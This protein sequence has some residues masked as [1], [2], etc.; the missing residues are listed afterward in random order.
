MNTAREWNDQPRVDIGDKVTGRAVYVEDVPE[1]PGTL[2]AAAIRS[3]YSH[4]RIGSIDSAAAERLPGVVAVLHGGNVDRFDIKGAPSSWKQQFIAGDRVRFD[5]DL[6]GLVVAEDAR[7]AHHA[8][9]LVAVDY[10]ALPT[11]FSAQEAL[12][13]DAELIHDELDSNLALSDVWEWGDVQAGL[14]DADVV[15]TETYSCPTIYQHP[16]EPASSFLVDCST[17]VMEVWAPNNKP[18]EI[19]DLG[20]SLF[21]WP[22]DKIRSRVP[23][24]GGNFG[25][26]H[27]TPELLAGIV[28]SHKIRRP[29]K[30]IVSGEESFRSTSRHA[31]D[32]TITMGLKADGTITA[33]DEY[34]AINT[35]AYFTGARVATGN[36]VTAGWG[37]YRI[38]NFRVRAHTAYTNRVP[39]GVFRNTGKNQPSFAIDSM[40]DDAARRMGINPL[41]L[42]VKNLLVRG[43]GLPTETWKRDGQLAPAEVLPMD[44]DIEYLIQ[45]A[46]EAIGWDGRSPAP[47][48]PGERVSRGRGLAISMR[49]GSGMGQATALASV[50]EDGMVSISH[51]AP[52]VGAGEF[53]MISVVAS[54]TMEIP[55]SRIRVGAPD[56]SNELEF[57]GTSSQRTTVQMGSA[58]RNACDELKLALATAAS[59]AFGGAAEQWVVTGGQV[60]RDGQSYTFGDV[61]RA[62]GGG[63][64]DSRGANV[65]GEIRE[66]EYGAHDHW[67]PSAAA[68]ELE[69]D[70]DTGEV[71]LL[72]FAIAVDAGKVL[73]YRSAAGQLE[74]GVIMGIGATLTEELHYEEGQLLNA[75][76]FQYRLPLMR[77]LPEKIATVMLENGDGPGPFGSKGIGNAGPPV[78]SP[79]VGNAIADA[80]GVRLKSIP[81]TPEKVL[82]ALGALENE[83][84]K[85]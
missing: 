44:A 17:D 19:V 77:D 18:F 11:L 24:I 65:R 13:P 55:Q 15:F 31:F 64:I 61:V 22:K 51:N 75:D 45:Q 74:S 59:R 14:R 41:D 49:R 76:A 21:G 82:Q 84:V 34:F 63:H 54:R 73:H 62:S 53:T 16:M 1:P 20:H 32:I 78:P 6:V 29:I 23:Y 57:P 38:P 25:S 9:E 4:A 67:A 79:A 81:F 37:A 40:L 42:R 68:V 80:I 69:L 46:T 10:Q 27:V 43:E 12:R 85:P 26:R 52:E 7:T 72:Q 28:V 3:P 48:E 2:F 83:G 50:D 36:A 30:F 8:A 5:G 60:A 35:G 71:R 39:A 66:N 33:L 47:H 56:T 58:V 70:R